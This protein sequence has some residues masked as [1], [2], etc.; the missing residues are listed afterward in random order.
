LSSNPNPHPNPSRRLVD[1]TPADPGQ[2]SYRAK[3][4]TETAESAER[5]RAAPALEALRSDGESRFAREPSLLIPPAVPHPAAAPA[6]TAPAITRWPGMTNPAAHAVANAE[7][8]EV[9]IHIGRI[10]V[11]AVHEAASP[12]R[13][14]VPRPPPMSLDAYLAKRGRT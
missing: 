10:E 9:H 1:S 2:A 13:P 8:S 7:P 4:T 3:S 6:I 14:P 5:S 11:T 12:R